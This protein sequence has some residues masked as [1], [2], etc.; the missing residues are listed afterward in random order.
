ML[1]PQDCPQGIQS[2][3]LP[4][5]C[6]QRL[7]VQPPLV[8]ADT[9][10]WATPLQ[11]VAVRHVFCGFFFFFPLQVM[12]PSEIP[13]LP[14]RP[15]GERVSWCLET[16][17]LLWLPP[18]DGSP[19]V[20]LLSL[21]LSYVFCLTSFWRQWA[22]FLG[23]WCPLPVFRSCFVVFA[24]R[25]NDLLMNLWGRQWFPCPIPLPSWTAST[26]CEIKEN[27]H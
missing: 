23:A 19:S 5:A 8:V 3:P 25:S 17:P 10:V 1:A 27:V 18:W 4:E 12:L 14:H 21:F 7:H 16:S 13:K 22:A 24:Q 15:T 26:L 9:S 11:G 20:T 2:Q 6:N